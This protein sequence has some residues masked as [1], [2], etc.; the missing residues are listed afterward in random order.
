MLGG[1]GLCRLR[2]LDFSSALTNDM[3]PKA[4]MICASR[5]QHIGANRRLNPV[6]MDVDLY[7]LFFSSS[8]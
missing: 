3:V 1:V 2:I 4:N 5:L 8:M 7:L 6:N